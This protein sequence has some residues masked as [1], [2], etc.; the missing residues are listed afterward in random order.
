M[1]TTRCPTGERDDIVDGFLRP[2]LPS[3]FDAA[4]LVGLLSD[5][6]TVFLPAHRH[7]GPAGTT[8][9]NHAARSETSR[10]WSRN[11]MS[12]AQAT[13]TSTTNTIAKATRPARNI[14]VSRPPAGMWSGWSAQ[15][16]TAANSA[17]FDSTAR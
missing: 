14:P 8:S 6:D 3:G 12:R 16:I 13:T 9:R 17:S 1:K 10:L 15:A 2:S 11:R 7:R 5:T 4:D